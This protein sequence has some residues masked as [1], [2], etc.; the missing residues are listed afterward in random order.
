M[1]AYNGNYNEF[2]VDF[3]TKNVHS[4]KNQMAV[5]FG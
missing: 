3:V 4:I 2:L 1:T 5:Y